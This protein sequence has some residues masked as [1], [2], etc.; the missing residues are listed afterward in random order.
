MELDQK[1][2]KPLNTRLWR[3]LWLAAVLA[4]CLALPLGARPFHPP[5]WPAP[6][7]P[8]L[9][10]LSWHHLDRAPYP[11]TG[12]RNTWED[13]PVEERQRLYWPLV[14]RLSEA[15]GLDPV[16][17]MAVVQVESRFNPWAV[18]EK[19]AAG[20]MQITPLTGLELGLLNPL[21]P[22]Q[23]LRAGVRYLAG[24]KRSFADD[25]VLALAAY[26]AGPRR[27]QQAGG[28]VP[29]IGQTRDFVDQ[30]L[31][32]KTEFRL[33]FSAISRR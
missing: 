31:A 29:E 8:C 19:G 28:A 10:I 1:V 30:V 7:D 4:A 3:G 33:R 15:E 5:P 27:V 17:V 24:L 11:I 22:E 32:L 14:R 13:P 6:G 25:E 16:L 21:H 20:L 23:N 18:S 12:P 9:R 26:N 2:A